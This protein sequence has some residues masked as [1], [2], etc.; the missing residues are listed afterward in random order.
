MSTHQTTVPAAEGKANA[1]TVS[2]S[3]ELLKLLSKVAETHPRIATQVKAASSGCWE[4][5][6]YVNSIGRP[7]INIDRVPRLVYRIVYEIA[8]GVAPGGLHVCHHCDNPI[9]TRPSHLFLGTDK[10]NVRDMWA[11]GRAVP[12]PTHWGAAHPQAHA[13]D[14]VVREAREA[15]AQGE[16]IASIALRVKHADSTVAAWIRGRTRLAAG[17]PILG[18]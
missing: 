12:P 4:W 16:A 5:Q 6:G 10:D 18:T 13:E 17:G 14:Q 9:C 3:A 15:F 1:G 7:V 8:T 11:K 2:D